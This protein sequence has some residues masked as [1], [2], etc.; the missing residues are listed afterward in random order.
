MN[1]EEY[2]NVDEINMDGRILFDGR[3]TMQEKACEN[4]SRLSKECGGA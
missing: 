2:S 3:S 4:V 1:C